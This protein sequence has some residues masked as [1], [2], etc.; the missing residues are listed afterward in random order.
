MDYTNDNEAY[1][2]YLGIEAIVGK[3]V[4]CQN[5]SYVFLGT[6]FNFLI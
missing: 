4:K 5:G 6:Q 1:L 3:C 2:V